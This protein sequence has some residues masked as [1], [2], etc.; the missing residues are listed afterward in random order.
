LGIAGFLLLVAPFFWALSSLVR[1]DSDDDRAAALLALWPMLL[2][3]GWVLG[4]WRIVQMRRE[5]TFRALLPLIVLA[6]ITGTFMSQQVW[7]STYGIWPLLALLVADLFATFKRELRWVRAGLAAVFCATLLACGSLYVK[8][9]ERLS[10]AQF[11]NGPVVRSQTPELKG[12]STPGPYVPEL[13]QLLRYVKGNIPSE[14]GIVLIPGEDPFYFATGRKPQFPVLLF[15]P[16]TDPYTPLDVAALVLK[17]NIRW[18]IVKRDLQ[19]RGNPAPDSQMLMWT[20]E[21]EF[22]L[23]TQLRGYDIYYRK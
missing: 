6:G 22:E 8:S 9:E 21:Q 3:A 15:D 2:F 12:M 4:L 13:D 11:P 18:L 16:T 17:N 10:Y 5:T 7:G 19:I 14:D 20:L 23:T 1:F